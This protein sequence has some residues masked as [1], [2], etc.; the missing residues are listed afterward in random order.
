MRSDIDVISADGRV[1]CRVTG[2][3]DKRFDLPERFF[4]ARLDPAGQP[5][6]RAF[7]AWDTRPDGV[8][9]AVLEDISDDLLGGSGGIWAG[10]LAGLVLTANERADWEALRTSAVPRRQNDWLRGRVAA[11]DAARLTAG[12][13]CRAADIAVDQPDPDGPP[14]LR[15]G[16]G[17]LFDTPPHLSIS[18]AG[19]CAAAAVADPARYSGVGLDLER[20][21]THGDSFLVSAFL[22]EE[23]ALLAECA[24][25]PARDLLVTRLWCAKEAAAKACGVG[26][27]QM[28]DRFV[29]SRAPG[30]ADRLVLQDT[31]RSAPLSLHHC[32]AH[33]AGMVLAVVTRGR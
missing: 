31:A 18:H 27:A 2:W 4:R 25:G 28:R 33:G 22:P 16:P 32:A 15:P 11:K 10:V 13:A 29:V 14:R 23:R 24:E 1:Q 17:G 8:S 3:W 30:D 12:R 7:D 21:E 26:V 9:V 19:G 6:S 5:V 20:V